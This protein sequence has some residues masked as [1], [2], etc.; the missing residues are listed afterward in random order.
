MLRA[1]L[2]RT[3]GIAFVACAAGVGVAGSA[4]AAPKKARTKKPQ[5]KEEAPPF[6]RDA[7]LAAFAE[8]DLQK[9]RVTNAPTGEGHVTVTFQPGGKATGA[10]VDRGPWL[11]T[12]VAKC[13]ASQYKK[14]RVPAFKGGTVNVGKTFRLD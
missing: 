4:D 12:P 2:L 14:A 5:P 13:I 3:L 8:V 6:D 1:S 11:G 7:A 10:I 9:C